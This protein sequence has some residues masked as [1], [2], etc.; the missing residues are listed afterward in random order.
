MAPTKPN[1]LVLITRLFCVPIKRP[2]L[3][4]TSI[5]A[6]GSLFTIDPILRDFVEYVTSSDAFHE[7]SSWNPGQVNYKQATSRRTD[8]QLPV[9][10]RE[11]QSDL[12]PYMDTLPTRVSM[13]APIR[14]EDFDAKGRRRASFLCTNQP[15]PVQELTSGSRWLRSQGYDN[16]RDVFMRTKNETVSWLSLVHGLNVPTKTVSTDELQALVEV[17]GDGEW[18]K[19]ITVR[20]DTSHW[21]GQARTI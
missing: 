12:M 7:G 17:L 3:D 11:F 9:S 6:V 14:A 21:P 19:A 13:L 1:I 5:D 10:L 20:V 8:F 15:E 2:G 16:L 4:L 18:V